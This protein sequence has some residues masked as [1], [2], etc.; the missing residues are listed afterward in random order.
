MK[1]NNWKG[2]RNRLD[3]KLKVKLL[4]RSVKY[5]VGTCRWNCCGRIRGTWA[6]KRKWPTV[7]CCCTVPRST[8]SA[9]GSSKVK[10]WWP[11]PA[12]FSTRRWKEVVWES[13]A[14]HRKWSSGPIWSTAA[15]VIIP[16]LS[17]LSSVHYTN[18]FLFLFLLI[19]SVILLRILQF[20]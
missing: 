12:T 3:V 5:A 10:T 7:G 13:S 20:G 8:W 1:T 19:T 14:S 11:I 9:W 18:I 6:G 4:M 15:T 16:K 2:L 17:Q